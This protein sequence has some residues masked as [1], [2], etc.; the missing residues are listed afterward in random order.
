MST[1]F[2]PSTPTISRS[3]STCAFANLMRKRAPKSGTAEFRDGTCMMVYRDLD[4]PGKVSGLQNRLKRLVKPDIASSKS[5]RRENVLK[6][7]NK[8]S[9]RCRTQ[10]AQRASQLKSTYGS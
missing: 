1:C 4:T 5:T 8:R 9:L 7:T 3:T 10:V 6:T 2:Q